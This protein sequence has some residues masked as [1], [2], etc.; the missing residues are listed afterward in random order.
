MRLLGAVGQVEADGERA[1]KRR[2]GRWRMISG[3]W[4]LR[5]GVGGGRW[6]RGALGLVLA[7]FE[8]C[9]ARYGHALTAR[10]GGGGG[11]GAG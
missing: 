6:S 5:G 3:C 9:R 8:R 4:G 10:G 2:T 11:G 1:A 7:G